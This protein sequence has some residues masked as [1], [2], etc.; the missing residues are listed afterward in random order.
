MTRTP[1]DRFIAALET[2]GTIPK[3]SGGV[4]SGEISTPR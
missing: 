4:W 1:I 3:R 2:K